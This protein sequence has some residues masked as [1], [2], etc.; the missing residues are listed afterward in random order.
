MLTLHKAVSNSRP[1][2]ISLEEV[3]AR[4]NTC[5]DGDG[6]NNDDDDFGGGDSD[7]DGNENTGDSGGGETDDSGIPSPCPWC[8]QAAS[9]R[10]LPDPQTKRGRKGTK[11]KISSKSNYKQDAV[12]TMQKTDLTNYSPSLVMRSYYDGLVWSGKGFHIIWM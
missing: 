11:H 3:C 9:G 5:G 6:K 4:Q 7:E 10:H 2:D 8:L 1:P 12:S